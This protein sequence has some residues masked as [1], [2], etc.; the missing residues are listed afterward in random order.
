M[1]SDEDVDD[2]QPYVICFAGDMLGQ[3]HFTDVIDFDEE[4]DAG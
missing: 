1:L 2:S 4:S 3:Q